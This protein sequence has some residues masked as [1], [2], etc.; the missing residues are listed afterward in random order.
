MFYI[1]CKNP[2]IWK[3]T[4]KSLCMYGKKR[5]EKEG[6]QVIAYIVLLILMDLIAS[7]IVYF[8]FLFFIEFFISIWALHLYNWCLEMNFQN[9]PILYQLIVWWLWRKETRT[10]YFK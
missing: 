2:F 5:R 6:M 4:H 3:Y 10:I 1:R 8:L 9:L 7:L